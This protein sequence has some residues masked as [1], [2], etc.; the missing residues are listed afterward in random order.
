VDTVL[1]GD[2]DDGGVLSELLSVG[3]TERRVGLGKD[4]VLLEVSDEL[5]L[6]ALD[7]QLD[8]V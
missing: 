1:L 2:L 4:V 8:L 5:G 6:R 3:T 7:R